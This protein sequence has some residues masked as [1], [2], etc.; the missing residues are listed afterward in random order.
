MCSAL[1]IIPLSVWTMQ[2]DGGMTKT[3]EAVGE[4]AAGGAWGPPGGWPR[5]CTRKPW[6]LAEMLRVW[7]AEKTGLGCSEPGG[8]ASGGVL[9]RGGPVAE[10]PRPR[11]Q[12]WM[13]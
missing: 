6:A 10:S 3:E 13:L 11:P 7:A 1:N 12:A 9:S 8:G 5:I 2:N 4:P